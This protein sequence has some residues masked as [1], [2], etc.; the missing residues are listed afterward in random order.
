MALGVAEQ[1]CYPYLGSKESYKIS[2]EQTD[3]NVVSGKVRSHACHAE[4]DKTFSKLTFFSI[5]KKSFF[6]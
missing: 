3:Y 1:Q 5:T 4:H 2:R 6:V